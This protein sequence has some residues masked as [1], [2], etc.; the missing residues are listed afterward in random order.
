[1]AVVFISNR[2]LYNKIIQEWY[3]V[4]K[5]LYKGN[6]FSVGEIQRRLT[7]ALCNVVKSYKYK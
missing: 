6:T 4:F 2:F 3:K 1:M 7:N 5:L